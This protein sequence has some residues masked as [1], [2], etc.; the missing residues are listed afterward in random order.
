MAQNLGL[1]FLQG[2][3]NAVA[4]TVSGPIDLIALALRKM[5]FPVPEDPVLSAKW[6]ADR[7][8]TVQ[9]QNQIAGMAGETLGNLLPFA[10]GPRTAAALTRAGENLAA[11]ATLN[12]QLGATVWH[13]SPHKFDAFDAGKIGTGEGAQAYG[14]GLYLADAPGVAGG[15]AQKLAHDVGDYG[16]LNG[17]PASKLTG[18][19]FQAVKWFSGYEGDLKTAI[20]AAKK[21]G[22]PGLVDRLQ[23]I[24]NGELTVTRGTGNLY[25]V[26]LPDSAIAKML[27]WDK[28]LS[29]QHPDVQKAFGQLMPKGAVNPHGL[30]MG[31]G[32]KILDNRM[33]QAD[34]TQVQPWVLSTGKSKFGLSQKDVDRMVADYGAN[35]TG[36]NAYTRLTGSLGGQDQATAALRQAGIPGIRY[37]DGGS[38]GAG[39]G[40][41]NYVVFPGEE[42]S[43]KILERNG[44][45]LSDLG[46]K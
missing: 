5:G 43:L 31:G 26:D 24:A 13:G 7:G 20:S 8:I 46:K 29:Q 42:S 18:D 19:D 37:L 30:D 3:S 39:T 33:G 21:Y 27:D 38:R 25:K 40:S 36:E 22:T 17:V 45:R 32:G 4:S 34:P 6:M 28:P 11:P 23:K 10:S 41:S 1:D 35:T 2:A 44:T 9:P 12:R 16:A 15:Y 14:H